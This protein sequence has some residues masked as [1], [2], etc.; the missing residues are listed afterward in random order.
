VSLFSGLEIGR[1][2]L[3]AQQAVLDTVGHNLAN[4]AT[5]GYA[6]QRAELVA[7]AP[8]DGVEVAQ[9]VRLRDRFLDVQLV[10]EQ[11]MLGHA[12]AQVGLLQRLESIFT[13][14][15][16]A[17]LGAVLGRF[18]AAFQDLSVHPTD[19][20]LRVTVRD[21]GE[22]LAATFR[23]LRQ[24]LDVLRADLLTEIQSRVG[25]AN[26]LVAE[27][28]ELNRRIVAAR[29]GGLEPSDLL[30]RRDLL[31]ARLSEIVGVAASDNPD[32]SARLIVAGTGVRLLD[33][34]LVSTLTA[35]LDGSTN[36]VR[37]QVGDE[38]VTPQRGALAA[39]LEARS[40]PTGPIGQAASDLDALARSIIEA[41][42]RLHASGVG[43]T[44]HT[45]LTSGAVVSSSTAA[46]TAA[47]LPST[48]VTGSFTI[49]VHDGAG[50][51]VSSI[52]VPV[53]AGV[54]TLEDV[55]S[56]I[57]GDPNLTATIS[58]GRL[59]V[60][61]AAG[62]TFAFSSDTSD[63]LMALGLNTFFTGRDAGTMAV[64]PLVS[65]DVG[66]IAAARVDSAGLAHP[67]DGSNA[68]ALARLLT[69]PVPGG[70]T[71]TVVD[72]LGTLL[73]R[74]GSQARDAMQALDRQEAA[75]R[76]VRN[77]QQQASGVSMDEELLALTQAQYAYAAAARYISTVN[78]VIATLFQI[79]R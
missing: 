67:G 33:G 35:T 60:S 12:Q 16:Q 55:R 8:R 3:T 44:E 63:T 7:V 18:F 52:E 42:N 78:D 43:L 15:P 57:D 62:M 71:A 20:A 46:L 27:I 5:P 14:D 75:V 25:A 26:G 65:Q 6:R 61:A 76:L 34:D 19:Q 69:A 21:A 4:V 58:G 28:A 56:A 50:A 54:T 39:L 30:D 36:T 11:G 70:G 40:A 9:I 17:G 72:F 37:L 48:P 64:N 32:G 29:G 53:M 59:T 73:S 38:V 51:L 31:V 74:V 45:T 79:S 13:E 66:K 22:Q 47:G 1:K 2:A 23:D 49:V 24:R 77:L 41:V 10:Q 68:L